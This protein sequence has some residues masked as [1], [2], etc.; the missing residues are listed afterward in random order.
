MINLN[1]IDGNNWF[2]MKAETSFGSPVKQCFQEIQMMNGIVICCWD[3]MYAKKAR[4]DLYPEYKAKRNFAGED[5]YASQNLLKELLVFSKAIQISIEGYE[6]D[7]IIAKLVLQYKDKA[8]IFIN[9]NDLDLYQL[10]QPMRRDSFPDKPE[11][12]KIYKTMTGDPSDNIPGARGFGKETWK[13]LTDEQKRI[14]EAVIA[15]GHLLTPTEVMEK[16]SFL[17][18]KVVNWMG[19]P[20]NMKALRLYYRIIGFIEISDELMI[21]NTSQGLNR[22]DLAYPIM[23]QYML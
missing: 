3:G 5:I 10:G 4:K 11:Y 2:R 21:K 12:I 22:P 6:A 19:E 14:I 9:S 1:I 7:D 17:P 16:V 18:P 20:E 23:E 15:S 13:K 8:K